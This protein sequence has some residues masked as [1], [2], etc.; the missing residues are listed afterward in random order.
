MATE[1]KPCPFCGCRAEAREAKLKFPDREWY[2]VRCSNFNCIANSISPEYDLPT[3]AFE[4][5]NRR[6]S[7][8]VE[9]NMYDKEEIFPDC[10][11]QVLTN[12]A[13]GE[14]SVGWWNNGN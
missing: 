9:T 14:T 13:T 4:A 3:R 11:V 8:K 1:L 10:T 2:G 5:W 7:V 12:T 6:Y